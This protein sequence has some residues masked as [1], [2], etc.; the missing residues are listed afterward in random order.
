M[1]KVSYFQPKYTGHIRTVFYSPKV[2]NSPAMSTVRFQQ[3][4]NKDPRP[5]TKRYLKSYCSDSG[6]AV[7]DP[8]L[9]LEAICHKS[10]VQ[11]RNSM[12]VSGN[13]R[14]WRIAAADSK[15][16]FQLKNA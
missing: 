9:R 8:L 7:Q 1:Y 2:T 6:A 13:I 5:T 4:M 12:Q 16:L 15:F 11:R 3:Q 10:W 14:D